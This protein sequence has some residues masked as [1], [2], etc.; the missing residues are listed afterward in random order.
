MASK[1]TRRV[2]TGSHPPS[3][4]SRL[5]PELLLDIFKYLVTFSSPTILLQICHHWEKIASSASS[6]WVRIDFSTPPTPLLRLSDDRPIEVNL[7]SSSKGPTSDQFEAVKDVLSLHKGRIRKLVLDLPMGHIQELET[8][9]SEIFPIL[10]DV[11]ISIPRSDYFYL[12]R[13]NFPTWRPTATPSSPIR[14]LKL[15]LVRTPWVPG[16]FQGLVEFYLHDQWFFDFDP[17][18][19]VFLGIL[20]SSPQ[21]TVL[22]VANAGPRLAVEART[23]PPATR[24]VHL[25]NLR[26]LYLEQDDPC[27]VGWILIH[28]K[29][30]I[31]A[32]I[33]IFVDLVSG[34][35]AAPPESLFNLALPNHPGF[36]HL[37]EFYRWTYAVDLRPACLITATNFAFSAKWDGS[38]HN[39]FDYIMMPFLRHV[40]AVGV[41]ENLSIVDD[42]H[43]RYTIGALQWDQIFDTLGAL[44][45]LRVEQSRD[46]VDSFVWTLQQSQPCSTLRD[47]WLSYTVFGGRQA[48]GVESGV[49]VGR[50][51]DFCSGRNE[52]GH[53]LERLIIEV[54]LNPPLYLAPLLAP[55]VD[56]VEI[57]ENSSSTEDI[58]ALEFGSRRMF[59]SLQTR[60]HD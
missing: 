25:R 53:R 7:S 32:N 40:T 24:T 11:S 59:D 44:K 58:W 33:R 51:V 12:G 2:R 28:L 52:K 6:L 13:R 23:L 39:H 15:L 21:L 45:K 42:Q 1:S 5:P 29:I 46:K 60:R 14:C 27:Q 18:I 41:I 54:P 55:Y 43:T 9:L 49:A 16:H 50:L 8:E 57:M 3:P 35:N 36:P 37:T 19:E 34:Q 38:R 26:R 4:I 22:S 31:S 56:H 20:E 48:S 47:L 10:A 17:P 30:P